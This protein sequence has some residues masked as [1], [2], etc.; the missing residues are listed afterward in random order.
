MGTSGIDGLYLELITR[1]L[2]VSRMVDNFYKFL[3]KE[4][5]LKGPPSNEER[6]EVYRFFW[7]NSP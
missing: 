4:G 3:K 5:L 1:D 7:E 6:R 2:E